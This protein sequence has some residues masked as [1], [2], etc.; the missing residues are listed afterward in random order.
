MPESDNERKEHVQ[1]ITDLL[2]ELLGLV[3]EGFVT[4]ED[5]NVYPAGAKISVNGHLVAR[6]KVVY[7]P[8]AERTFLNLEDARPELCELW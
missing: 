6:L 8:K 1:A 5:P 3:I 2:S 4:I 7:C